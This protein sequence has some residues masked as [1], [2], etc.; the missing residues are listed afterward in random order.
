M[1]ADFFVLPRT[2]VSTPAPWG[3]DVR[4]NSVIILRARQNNCASCCAYAYIISW[5]FSG[6]SHFLLGDNARDIIRAYVQ[7]DALPARD[8]VLY[9]TLGDTNV[10]RPNAKTAAQIQKNYSYHAIFMANLLVSTQQIQGRN[11]SL[12]NSRWH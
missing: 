9:T 8:R 7:C 5:T 11:Y 1:Q 6:D 3:L 12:P 4:V 2:L 10:C